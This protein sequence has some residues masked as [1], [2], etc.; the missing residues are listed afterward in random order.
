MFSYF[1]NYTILYSPS[2]F[3]RFAKSLFYVLRTAA[4]SDLLHLD[5]PVFN[6]V[7]GGGLLLEIVATFFHIVYVHTYLLRSLQLSKRLPGIAT[8]FSK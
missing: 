1:T 6:F 3:S 5:F 7:L 4:H 8:T 2:T